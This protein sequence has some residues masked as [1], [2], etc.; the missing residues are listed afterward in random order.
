MSKAAT[1][2]ATKKADF[3]L[4]FHTPSGQWCKKVK[5]KVYYFGTDK[6]EAAKRWKDEKDDIFAGVTP[7]SRGDKASIVELANVFSAD[8]RARYQVTGKPGLRHI[9]LCEMTLKRLIV[10]MGSGFAAADL[11]PSHFGK[12][13]LELFKP[14][15]RTK[16]VQGK[17]FGRVVTKR[18]PETVAGDIRRIKVFLNWCHANEYTPAPRYGDQFA[19]ETA[20]AITKATIKKQGRKDFDAIDIQAVID[21]SGINFKP[22][23]L[24][25]IN[26]GLGAG[27]IAAMEF[28]DIADID[29]KECWIDLARLKT[30][31]ERRFLLWPETQKAIQEYLQIRRA[32]IRTHSNIV[33][34]TSHGLPWVRGEGHHKHVDTAGSTFTKIRKVAGVERGSFY[35][36][37]RTFATVACETLDFEAVRRC[38][39]HVKDNR[40]M[41]AGYVQGVSDDRI[42][43]VCNHVRQWLFGGAK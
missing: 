31:A 28:D 22:I 3:P 20:V 35:D 25:A 21:H 10:Q 2:T 11:S 30:G 41:L 8:Q 6:D 37:R 24:L 14:I 32:P 36:M 42:R 23:V 1:K 26:S 39:G 33:F 5:Q 19:T 43:T 16:A 15:A 18:A 29:S 9:E 17:V 40:D 27:D 38:M 12:I 13:K 34:L 7:K 4:W